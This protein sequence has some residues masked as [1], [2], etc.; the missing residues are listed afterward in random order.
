MTVVDPRH[1]FVLI[2]SE[3]LDQRR[4]CTHQSGSR[5][6][7]HQMSLRLGT[8]MSYRGQQLRIGPRQPRQGPRIQ[9]IIFSPTLPDQA[10][11]ARMRHDHL[12]PQLAQQSAHTG[13]CIPVS[14]AIR[15]RV[16]TPNTSF[17]AFRSRAQFLFQKHFLRSVKNT[18][19]NWPVSQNPA[20]P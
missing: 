3:S 9:P 1:R 2:A 16:I 14:N 15:F 4:R 19:S 13:E 10:H 8:A 5:S 6:D 20:G 17:M 7:Q 11:V 12:V 18:V